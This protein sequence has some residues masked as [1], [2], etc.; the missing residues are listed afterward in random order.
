MLVLMQQRRATVQFSWRASCLDWELLSLIG[1]IIHLSH[2]SCFTYTYSVI[3]TAACDVR[4]SGHNCPKCACARVT[5][6]VLCVSVCLD[7]ELFS[8]IGIYTIIHFST[9]PAGLHIQS[10]WS[11]TLGA[12]ARV[13][14]IYVCLSV[15]L[16]P[17]WLLQR[18]F[19]SASNYTHR[20]LLGV[21]WIL[22]RGF[23]NNMQMSWSSP[24]T[25]FGTNGGLQLPE[26]HL[27]SR[28]LLQRLA[29]GATG[30]K[31]ARYTQ[32]PTDYS[33]LRGRSLHVS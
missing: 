17:L 14:C 13:L 30:V 20:F 5:V 11:L 15:Y 8:L 3:V 25:I 2:I 32:L 1:T 16:L 29:T 6:V 10:L 9:G 22:T 27:V 33:G 12:H 26:A 31:Q 19:I 18:P 23:S 7:W 24:R 28:M 21:S 4:G